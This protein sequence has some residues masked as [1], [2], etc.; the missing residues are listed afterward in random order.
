MAGGARVAETRLCG[1][2]NLISLVV[3]TGPVTPRSQMS[4]CVGDACRHKGRDVSVP[5]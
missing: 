1:N 4:S 5:N 3:V 2:T